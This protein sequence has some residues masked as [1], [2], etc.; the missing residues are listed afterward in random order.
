MTSVCVNRNRS[1]Y[2]KYLH[3]I[4]SNSGCSFIQAD[5]RWLTWQQGI[6]WFWTVF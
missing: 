4:L 2:N 1:T 5:V 6:T 3:I